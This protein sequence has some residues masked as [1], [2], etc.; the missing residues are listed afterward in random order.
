MH[1]PSKMDPL[2]RIHLG[3]KFHPT[4]NS[5]IFNILKTIFLSKDEGLSPTLISQ[6]SFSSNYSNVTYMS[7]FVCLRCFGVPPFWFQEIIKGKVAFHVSAVT[8]TEAV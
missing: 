3:P 7:K 8:G 4:A 6:C 1:T 5:A 2:T